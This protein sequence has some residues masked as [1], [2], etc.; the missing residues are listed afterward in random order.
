MTPI[1][2]YIGLAFPLIVVPSKLDSELEL[3][4]GVLSIGVGDTAAS[5][6]GSKYGKYK[7]PGKM[8]FFLIY[9]SVL[10]FDYAEIM[11]LTCQWN[12]TFITWP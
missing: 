5:W 4:S 6:F 3:L 11:F 12:T 9:L 2:L 10:F 8:C 1:Y 7:W